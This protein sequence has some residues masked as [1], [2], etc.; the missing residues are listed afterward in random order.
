MAK[1]VLV[2]Q[3]KVSIGMDD[4]VIKEVD[5]RPEFCPPCWG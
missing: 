3:D 4:G 1:I 2:E 5:G